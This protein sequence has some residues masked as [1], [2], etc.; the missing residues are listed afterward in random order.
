MTSHSSISKVESRNSGEKFDAIIFET[1]QNNVI[2]PGNKPKKYFLTLCKE[3]MWLK[4]CRP[5]L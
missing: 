1:I 2:A 5:F 4:S 3:H